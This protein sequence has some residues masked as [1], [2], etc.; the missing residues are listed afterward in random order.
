MSE[1]DQRPTMETKATTDTLYSQ[2]PLSVKIHGHELGLKPIKKQGFVTA[3]L[4]KHLP[5]RR[6]QQG[7]GDISHRVEFLD[8]RKRKKVKDAC[9]GKKGLS[10]K[11]RKR[12]KLFDI[13]K[14]QQRYEDY[15]PLNILWTSYVK[16]LIDFQHLNEKNHVTATM[17]FMKAD[18]HGC[19]ITVQRSK[20]ASYVGTTGIVLKESRNMFLIITAD[21]RV[22]DIP[23]Q[24]S[25]FTVKV[26]GFLFTV[27]GNHFKV[28]TAER[29]SRRFKSKATIDL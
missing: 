2:L 10:N 17:K 27:H 3:F 8:A 11:D 9:V 16:D 28:K 14:D 20:C 18:L 21:N 12:L 13:K 4:E 25:V 6:L 26:E 1:I 19:I 5:V 29:P 24:N 22:K 23:K 7:E 15:L